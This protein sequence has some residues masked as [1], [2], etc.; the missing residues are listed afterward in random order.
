[1]L[2]IVRWT[3]FEEVGR[4]KEGLQERRV[5]KFFAFLEFGKKWCCLVQILFF[6]FVYISI[7]KS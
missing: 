6:F 7:E 2:W 4:R 5:P 1:M 3:V